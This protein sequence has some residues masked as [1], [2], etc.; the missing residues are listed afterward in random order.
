MIIASWCI[1]QGVPGLSFQ[2]K[3]TCYELEGFRLQ[4]LFV[5]ILDTS[6]WQSPPPFMCTTSY[7]TGRQV[8][9]VIQQRVWSVGILDTRVWHNPTIRPALVRTV[10]VLLRSGIFHLEAAV[11]IGAAEPGR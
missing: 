7:K 10:D 4:T 11:V 3:T 1:A 2:I 8:V 9:P 6:K 5:E